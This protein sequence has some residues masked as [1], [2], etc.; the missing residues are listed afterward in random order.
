MFVQYNQVIELMLSLAAERAAFESDLHASRVEVEELLRSAQ[1]DTTSLDPYVS[2][3]VA[4]PFNDE[5]GA[6]IYQAVRAVLEDHPYFWRVVRADDTVEQPGLWPNLKTKLLRAHCYI[7]ILTGTLNPNVMIETGRMEA[8]QRPL[9]LLRDTAAAE[10]PAN[11]KGLLYEELRTSGAD[12]TG[13]VREAIVRQDRLRQLQ[14][15]RYLSETALKRYA[16][17][18]GEVSRKISRLFPTWEQFIQ[19][20]ADH[21]ARQTGANRV[22]IQAAQTSLKEA[23]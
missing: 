11:L 22:T 14:G 4:M 16:F 1:G 19:A 5:R 17:L 13:E 2:C 7:A 10:L 21:V 18:E 15:S 8:L 6:A 20:D 23:E 12:L 3:F 9:L